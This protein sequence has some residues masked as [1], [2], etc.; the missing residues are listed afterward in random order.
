[1]ALL[2]MDGFD[3]GDFT[4]K[5][6]T[7]GGTSA[8]TRFGVGRSLANP[9][10]IRFTASS[11]VFVGYAVQMG[12]YSSNFNG[13]RFA[14][15]TDNGTTTHLRLYF[16]PTVQLY[17][18][19]G[20]L[21][22]S[23]TMP[24]NANPIN[25]WIYVE[26]SA[27]IADA[28]GT[29]EVRVNGV[30]VINF[31]GDTR[32]GGTSTNIDSISQAQYDIGSV[33]DDLYVCN[34]IGSAPH[35]TFLGEIRIHSLSPNAAGS[36]TQWTPDTGTNF[37][38]VNEVPYSAANYVQSGTSGQR[39]TYLIADLPAS[40]GSVLAVQ[41]NVIAKKTDVAPISIKPAIKSGASVYY[42]TTTALTVGDTT[43]MD[44]RVI[45]PNTS[46]AWTPSGVNA[47]EGGFEVA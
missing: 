12:G 25:S 10:M 32:S 4:A 41:N 26:V 46:S 18:N 23:G 17:R 15:H 1:M 6:W 43:T 11:Q 7:G 35:N 39:D 28:G 13:Y 19:D 34:S 3:L 44:L 9:G 14:L 5:G 33:W 38:R 42:G 40:A 45:D 27:T 21:L 31:T 30:T 37:S 20:T 2:F 16:N 22:A 24:A 47:L 36:S 29:C 8:S